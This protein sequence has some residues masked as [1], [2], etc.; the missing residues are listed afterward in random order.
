ME[1]LQKNQIKVFFSK[2]FHKRLNPKI[3]EFRYNNLYISIPIRTY[4]NNKKNGNF[5]IGLNR[6][7]LISVSNV[8]HGNGESMLK[9]IEDILKKNNINNANG[10][11]WLSTFPRILGFGFEPVSFWFCENV[12]EKTVAIIVEVNNTFGQRDVYVLPASKSNN[13]I[14]NGETLSSKKKFYVSPFIEI[15]GKY[16]FRFYR[17]NHSNKETS[18]IELVNNNKTLIVTSIS[19]KTMQRDSLFFQ[20][21]L[22]YLFFLPLL[23]L[24]RIHWQAA[25]LWLKGLKLVPRKI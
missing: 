4:F 22:I 24:L 23:T 8:H 14:K 6:Y 12:R 25:K 2:I 9:W 11:I 16:N 7:S 15:K 21:S 10:E 3:H 20:I 13:N 17:S 1:K 18:R 5:F 19:A